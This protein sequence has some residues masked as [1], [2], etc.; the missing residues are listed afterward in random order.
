MKIPESFYNVEFSRAT[1]FGYKTEEVDS[2]VETAFKLL[3]ELQEENKKLNIALEQTRHELTKYKNDE[4]MLRSALVGSQKLAYEHVSSAR[5]QSEEIVENARRQAD[6]II[7]DI[8][9]KKEEMERIYQLESKEIADFKNKVFELYTKHI[10]ILQ[11]IPEA[12]KLELLSGTSETIGTDQSTVQAISSDDL[13]VVKPKVVVEETLSVKEDEVL[14]IKSE[15]S[16]DFINT[17]ENSG[18]F[19]EFKE[20]GNITIKSKAAVEREVI[21]SA[22]SEQRP[23]DASLFA[24]GFFNSNKEI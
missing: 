18:Q 12:V 19:F 5:Q 24:D 21:P 13:G 14:D 8:S 16:N 6:E 11:S 2:F 23:L 17:P 22:S 4:E 15:K 7:A 20:D 10:G 3:D 1:M 9:Y